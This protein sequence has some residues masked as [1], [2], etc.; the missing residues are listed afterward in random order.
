MLTKYI[1]N[2]VCQDVFGKVL[3]VHMCES[4]AR[5]RSHILRVCLHHLNSILVLDSYRKDAYY[6]YKSNG[7]HDPCEM[8]NYTNKHYTMT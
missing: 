3:A 8:T 2:T 6:K 1:Y 4:S 5:Y 7:P